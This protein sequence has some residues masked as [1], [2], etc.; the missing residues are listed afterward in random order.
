MGYGPAPAPKRTWKQMLLPEHGTFM[1]FRKLKK[2]EQDKAKQAKEGGESLTI[3]PRGQYEA[4]DQFTDLLETGAEVARHQRKYLVGIPV[5]LMFMCGAIFGTSG[6]LVFAEGL[7]TSAATAVQEYSYL[8]QLAIVMLCFTMVCLCASISPTSIKQIYYTNIGLVVYFAICGGI[9]CPFA[10]PMLLPDKTGMVYKLWM[11]C[12]LIKCYG[13]ILTSIWAV[14]TQAPRKCLR[15]MEFSLMVVCVG[16]GIFTTFANYFCMLDYGAELPPHWFRNY[17]YMA[18]CCAV[19]GAMAV[20][21]VPRRLGK[22][23]LVLLH[24]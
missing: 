7:K 10:M 22:K 18:L 6:Y 8:V 2:A 17:L 13:Y 9:L 15:I 23:F 21:D 5:G 1:E 19:I 14:C 20:T 11:A 24:R 16:I 3:V 4:F 12:G